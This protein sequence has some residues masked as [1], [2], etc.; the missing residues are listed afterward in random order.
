MPISEATSADASELTKLVNSAY[1]GE[2][3]QKGWT[4]EAHLLDGIRI[5]EPTM[6]EYLA[7][8]NTTILKYTDHDGQIIGCVYLELKKQSLYL[9]MLTV[10]PTLQTKGI[11]RQ[12]L[13]EAEKI[14]HRLNCRTL[15]MTV[16]TTRHELIKWY[17]RRGYRATGTTMPFPETTKFGTPNQVIELAVFEKQV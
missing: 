9:G 8:A 15:F 7:D 10:S 12:L 11:G 13:H 2:S 14:A 6:S 17:E 1:R 16:I 3:S 4:S 5:D